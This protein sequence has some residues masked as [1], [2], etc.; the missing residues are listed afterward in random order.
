VRLC[1][2]VPPRVHQVRYSGIF[3][4]HARGRYALTGRGLHDCPS[5]AVSVATPTAASPDAGPVPAATS[6]P[7]A[8]PSASTAPGA[9]GSSNPAVDLRVQRVHESA[10]EY[11]PGPDDPGRARR[12]AWSELF[13]RVWREDIL[14]CG[15]C[16]GDM[17]LIAVITE[18]AVCERIM[19]HAGL[20][21]RGPPRGRHVVVE[22]AD[23][24]PLYVD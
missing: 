4:A 13:R 2:L 15:R 3:S 1:A 12:L 8:A 5:D 17:R 10:S 11:L 24:E 21:Q 6:L 9:L 7:P 23:R 20:W 22:P 18:P 14:R 16:G 19:R